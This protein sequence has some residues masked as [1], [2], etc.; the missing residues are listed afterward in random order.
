MIQSKKIAILGAG[1]S[2]IT[3]ALNLQEEGNEVIVF[4][5]NPEVGGVLQSK[6]MNGY[7]LDCGANT[8]SLRSQKKR[9]FL[10]SITYLNTH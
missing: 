10:K 6:R 2:G 9:L 1:L 7:L 5:Q 3:R 8:L 4:D